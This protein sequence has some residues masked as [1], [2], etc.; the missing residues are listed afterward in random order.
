M[1]SWFK[2][3]APDLELQG[4]SPTSVR[5]FFSFPL[6]SMPVHSALPPSNVDM[7]HHILG[8]DVKLSVPRDLVII[9]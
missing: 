5:T 1:V 2:T 9:S 3:C 8:G 6:F 4:S 7:F